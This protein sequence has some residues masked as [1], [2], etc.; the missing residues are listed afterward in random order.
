MSVN[1]R[2]DAVAFGD[3]WLSLKKWEGTK[4]Q[5]LEQWP[6]FCLYFLWEIKVFPVDPVSRGPEGRV[7]LSIFH[8]EY[9]CP[10]KIWTPKEESWAH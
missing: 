2:M 8:E 6:K 1:E 3:H 4:I 5:A 10:E 9:E 7:L